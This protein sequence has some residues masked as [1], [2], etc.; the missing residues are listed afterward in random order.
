MDSKDLF[1]LQE[2]IIG[3]LLSYI[4]SDDPDATCDTLSLTD[5]MDLSKLVNQLLLLCYERE[6]YQEALAI[7]IRSMQDRKQRFD[8]Q[9]E[10]IRKILDNILKHTGKQKIETAT[11]TIYKLQRKA[12]RLHIENE[13][14]FLL[15]NPNYTV[16][17]SKVDKSLLLEDLK[18][19]VI[20]EGAM[21]L[22]VDTIGIRK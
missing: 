2:L 4:E 14:E 8:K 22:N 17:F 5:D 20:V 13:A 1:H 12:Q 7:T 9:I 15:K 6:G 10:R 11:G 3:D 21:L 19:G 18:Q 16:Q